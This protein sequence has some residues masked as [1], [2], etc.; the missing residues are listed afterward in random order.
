MRVEAII[1]YDGSKFSGFQIQKHTKNTIVEHLQTTLLSLG[2]K[3][4]VIGSGRT[5]KGVHAT[6]QTIH[7]DIPSF[8]EQ[9]GL[10]ELKSRLNQ[11]LKHI[12]VKYI[13]EVSL[14]F[15]AQYSA[16][17]RVYRYIIK[18]KEPTVFEQPFVS[19][20][21]IKNFNLFKSAIDA[22]MGEHNFKFFKKEGSLT[23]S[24]IREIYKT[25]VIKLN[26]YIVVY[27]FAN[28]YL[29]SQ[30]RLMI[31]AAIALESKEITQKELAEQIGAKKRYITKPS[32]P[33]GL[34]LARVFY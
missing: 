33:N 14:D 12:R 6:F 21:K 2:I 19:Y 30:I 5:D 17:V 1:E 10:L 34:Y 11:K 15:H 31:A 32:C 23:S 20:Y 8:W 28:G 29:R 9:K 7:F 25:K 4:K 27:F 18:T 24:D 26:D 16:K 22:F 3:S 13:K